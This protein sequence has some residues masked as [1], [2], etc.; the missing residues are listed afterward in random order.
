MVRSDLWSA[1]FC[2]GGCENGYT[3]WLS[4]FL[5]LIHDHINS[6]QTCNSVTFYFMKNSFSDVSRKWILPNHIWWYSLPA[7]IRKWVFQEIKHD[8]ITSLLGIHVQFTLVIGLCS[9]FASG[10]SVGVRTSAGSK[11]IWKILGT[12]R[13][14]SHVQYFKE[15]RWVMHL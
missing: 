10:A 13:T 6:M 11:P 1:H 12:T 7:N 9:A 15:Q 14:W 5:T 3:L 4:T 2:V 8:R